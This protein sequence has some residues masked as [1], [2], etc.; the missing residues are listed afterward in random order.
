MSQFAINTNVYWGENKYLKLFTFLDSLELNTI[1]LIVDRGI[2]ESEPVAKII[3]LIRNHN[4]KLLDFIVPDVTQEPTYDDLE[5][6]SDQVKKNPPDIIFGIGGGTIIDLAKGTSVLLKNAGKGIDYRGMN[7][8]ANSALPYVAFPT[9]AGTGSEVTWTAAFIDLVDNKKLGING[10]NVAPTCALLDPEFLFNCPNAIAVGSGL[11]A[12]VHAVEAITAKTST[13]LTE[14]LGIKA[15]SMMH[16]YLP[17]FVEGDKSEFVCE[18]LLLS[19]YIAG[20]AMMNAGGGPASGISYP[21]GVHYKVPHGFAGGIFLQH[22]FEINI[23]NGYLGYQ[24][25]YKALHNSIT[26]NGDQSKK[27][28]ESFNSFYKRV[29]APTNLKKWN[30][31]GDEAIDK[32]YSLT[33]NERMENL[34]LNPIDF[35]QLDLKRL[36]RLVCS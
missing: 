6:L 31:S 24:K 30:C 25:I 9:T 21:L 20:I 33:L 13:E 34:E 19:S 8:V 23:E 22:V 17:M 5:I 1:S 12:M 36:L 3:Q 16:K 7:K 10:R 32:L 29:Q 14:T 4:F 28:L 26:N 35:T 15:F 27:F 11:D 18:Q 2:A